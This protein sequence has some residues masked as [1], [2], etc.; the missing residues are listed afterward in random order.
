MSDSH[1]T[2][3]S[4]STSFFRVLWTA[5]RDSDRTFFIVVN[6][7]VVVVVV[8]VAVV[9]PAA[10]AAAFFACAS[11]TFPVLVSRGFM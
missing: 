3:P 10:A 11:V 7:V 4:Y 6:V 2:K 8:V 1:L 9:L 5:I